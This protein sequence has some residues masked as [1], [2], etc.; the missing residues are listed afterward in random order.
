MDSTVDYTAS[1]ELLSA[2]NAYRNPAPSEAQM[3]TTG[4]DNGIQLSDLKGLSYDD[5]KWELFLDQITYDEMRTLFAE[6]GWHSVAID[7]L[8]I[9]DTRMLAGRLWWPFPGSSWA[10]TT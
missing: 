4:A 8:G 2:Y 7:R 1:E 10:L 3:P 5:P 9:P 6:G